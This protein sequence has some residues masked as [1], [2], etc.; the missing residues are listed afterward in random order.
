MSKDF[1]PYIPVIGW[2]VSFVTGI[3]TGGFIVPRLVAK[4]KII[5]WSVLSESDIIPKEISDR[6]GVPVTIQV[7]P[8]K[9]SSLSL[10]R[11][12]IGNSGND[13]VEDAGISVR[14]NDACDVLNV[15]PISKMGEYE[16][17]LKWTDKDNSRLNTRRL[18]AQF[19]NPGTSFDFEFLLSGYEPQSAVVDSAVKGVQLKRRDAL[20]WDVDHSFLSGIGFGIAG[21][22]Y[23]PATSAMHQVVEELRA[24]RLISARQQYDATVEWNKLSASF[25]FFKNESFT[26]REQEAAEALT[27]HN[28]NLYQQM[29]RLT[30]PIVLAIIED[31]NT[32][33]QVKAFLNLFEEYAAAV[34]AKVLD[35]DTAFALMSAVVVRHYNIFAEV[36]AKRRE[37]LGQGALWVELEKLALKWETPLKEE[38]LKLKTELAQLY[39]KRTKDEADRKEVE[40]IE[41]QKSLGLTGLRR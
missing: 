10:V 18:S 29:D 31:V 14:F 15:R 22:S 25:T 37:Q 38:D 36:I 24:L 20:R 40:R 26:L 19:L 11:V 28:V 33:R 17:I 41:Y 32:F 23:S 35:H 12:R 9:P 5:A 39:E 2:F 27:A 34:H 3:L 1:L 8:D 13:V 7:G 4:R 16:H 21:I 30:G 6:L